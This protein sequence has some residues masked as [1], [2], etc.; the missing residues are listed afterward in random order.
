M[1]EVLALGE[2]AGLQV[3]VGALAGLAVPVKVLRHGRGPKNPDPEIQAPQGFRPPDGPPPGVHGGADSFR[4]ARRRLDGPSRP[5]KRL[6]GA[7]NMAHKKGGGSSRNGRDSGPNIADARPLPV[8]SSAGDRSLFVDGATQ[9]WPGRNVGQGRGFYPFRQWWPRLYDESNNRRYI[10]C[11]L[12]NNSFIAVLIHEVCCGI[13]MQRFNMRLFSLVPG[14]SY[15]RRLW[16]GW[17][18]AVPGRRPQPD[19]AAKFHQKCNRP[20]RLTRFQPL[21]FLRQKE[22]WT[23]VK[24]TADQTG[25]VLSSYLTKTGFIT[26][27]E[28]RAACHISS[29]PSCCCRAGRPA[30]HS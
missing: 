6:T 13:I 4:R 26:I 28:A 21:S 10:H 17:E 12:P 22:S 14:C 2:G 16:P 20:G 27:D 1:G 15:W 29:H 25:W 24:T 18:H 5:G 19:V 8:K 30:A 7:G 11:S 23:Q 9:F 3:G